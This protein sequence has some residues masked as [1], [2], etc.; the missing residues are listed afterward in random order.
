MTDLEADA[1]M[2]AFDEI[3]NPRGKK[4]KI[5]KVRKP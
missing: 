4:G 2:D 3:I 5:Y 1:W